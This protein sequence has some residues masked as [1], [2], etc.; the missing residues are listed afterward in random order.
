MAK[1]FRDL[2]RDGNKDAGIEPTIKRTDAGMFIRRK[3]IHVEPGFNRR[4][5][6][7]ELTDHIRRLANAITKEV[8]NGDKD[9]R[10]PALFVSVREDGGVLMRDGH[11]RLGGYDLSALEG[12]P[13]EWIPI[14]PFIGTAAQ[15]KAFTISSNNQLQTSPYDRALTLQDLRDDPQ[16][17]IEGKPLTTTQIAELA[18]CSRQYVER[19][20]KVA[21]APPEIREAVLNGE[22][23]AN[24]AAQMLIKHGDDAPQAL[25]QEVEKAKAAGKKA[26]TKNTLQG[27]PIPRNLADNLSAVAVKLRD[28]L[29]SSAREAIQ[30]FRQGSDV[31]QTVTLDVRLLN[32]LLAVQEELDAVRADQ[33]A[34]ADKK[35][36]AANEKH[37]DAA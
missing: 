19:L 14:A 33:Q 37:Q 24:V 27:R 3:N 36:Q 10:I 21:D 31:Y 20:L 30:A 12:H 15:A 11:C 29:P 7:Q 35:A 32:E 9:T 16:F 26:I 2:T 4:S 5:P 17:F 6:S 18:G 23:T 34:K 1:T 25:A 22:V 13:A 8:K 28:A